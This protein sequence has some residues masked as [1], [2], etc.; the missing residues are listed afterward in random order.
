MNRHAPGFARDLK[1]K[2]LQRLSA[3]TLM[4]NELY[5]SVVYRP[6]AGLA[7][8]AASRLFARSRPE[9]ARLELKDSLDACEK[10]AQAFLSS[11]ARY[12]PQGLGVYEWQDRPYSS[13]LEFLGYFST[14]NGS[15]SH[16]RARPSPRYSPPRDPLFG[17]ETIEYR[18]PTRTRFGAM[19]GIIEYST[20]TVVGLFDA[21]LSTPFPWILTQSFAFLK[22][23]S[24]QGVA[25]TPIQSDAK[26]RRF[27]REP[28]RGASRR[29]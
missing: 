8:G 3:E 19:L 18:A 22:K 17:F 23:A 11:L 25:P 1:A 26:R 10:L 6:A 16:C 13:L 28:S 5:V 29:P 24:A 12:E 27:R 4:V 2:Y 15:A 7:V 9:E 20:P 21:L 14:A